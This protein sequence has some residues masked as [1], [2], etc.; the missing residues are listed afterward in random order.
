MEAKMVAYA[1][2]QISDS[3]LSVRLQIHSEIMKEHP[4]IRGET[5][6]DVSILFIV[7]GCLECINE[8]SVWIETGSHKSLL[9]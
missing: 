9:I 2:A 1:K 8:T 7:I 5:Y 4:Q 6:S 3:G